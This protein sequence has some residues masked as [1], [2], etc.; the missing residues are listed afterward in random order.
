MAYRYNQPVIPMA[1]SYRKPHFPFTVVN[2][3]RSLMGNQKLPM[4]TLRI[5][6]PLLFDEN[7]GRKEAVL[8][9]RKSCHEEVVRLAGISDNPYPAE[10]D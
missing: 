4:I 5:G 7:L 8:K 3:L 2:A 10:G 1:F 9:L 6:E